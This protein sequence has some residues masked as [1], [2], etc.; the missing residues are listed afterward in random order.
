MK[1]TPAKVGYN[2]MRQQNV[3]FFLGAEFKSSSTVFLAHQIQIS[4][5]VRKLTPEI[6]PEILV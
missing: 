5:Q 6:L 4:S 2:G 1:H 3:R